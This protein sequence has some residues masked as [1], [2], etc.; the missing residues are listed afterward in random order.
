MNIPPTLMIAIWTLRSV[1][2][3]M[4]LITMVSTAQEGTSPML[5]VNA[6]GLVGIV[7]AIFYLDRLGRLSWPVGQVIYVYV[8]VALILQDSQGLL[9]HL[10]SGTMPQIS[11]QDTVRL[12]WVIAIIVVGGLIIEALVAELAQLKKWAWRLSMGLAFAYILSL[13]FFLP[14][15]LSLWCLSN[16]ETRAAFKKKRVVPLDES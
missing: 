15:T 16:W 2:I 8:F 14:G 9:R 11:W 13:V 4:A 6:L 7:A 12:L 1:P 10:L 3:I 5:W